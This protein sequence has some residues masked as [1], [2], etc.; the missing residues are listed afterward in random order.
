MET[1]MALMLVSPAIPP[2]GEIP[3]QYTCDGTDISPPLS[4]SGVPQGTQSL[5]LV[6]ED[7]DAPSGVFR[8]WAAFEIPPGSHG[9]EAGYTAA[10]PAAGFREARNDFGKPG[11]S[12]PCPPKGHG[13]HHYDFRLLA[14]SQ[15]TL[16]LG[17]AA[18]AAEVLRAA[19][20]Y[21]IQQTELAGTYHR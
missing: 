7:P 11:Y 2:G 17:P 4:W 13:I 15:P 10:R 21:V 12:G 18:T 1:I 14:I 19:Q 6:V 16:Q 20:P 3:A 8:H 9:L 5:V